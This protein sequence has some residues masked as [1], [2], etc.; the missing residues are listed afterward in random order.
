MAQISVGAAT[1]TEMKER[2]SLFEDARP[3]PRPH[4]KKASCLAAA[5][6]CSDRRRPWTLELERR[7]GARSPD[8]QERA[9]HPAERHSRKRRPRWGRRR[10]PGPPRQR[11][12]FGYDADKDQ[13]CD[14]VEAGIIDPAKVVRVALQNAASVAALLLTTS[15][16]VTEIP[17]EQ[18]EQPAARRTRLADA[19]WVEWVA[20]VEWEAWVEWVAWE[21]TSSSTARRDSMPS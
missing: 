6:P 11:Q 12:A 2:K 7:R 18:P 21:V 10:E 9:A 8:R 13:Y 19:A 16:I 5:W 1:E 15:C 20:W 3:P 14:L 17:K 4:W